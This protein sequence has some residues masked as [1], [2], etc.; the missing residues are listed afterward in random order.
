MHLLISAAVIGA[1]YKANI[2]EQSGTFESTSWHRLGNNMLLR[3][4]QRRHA[5][6]TAGSGGDGSAYAAHT[7]II[8]IL[9]D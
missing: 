6:F 5:A 7:T 3:V 8:I 1:I 4:M 2:I 9:P